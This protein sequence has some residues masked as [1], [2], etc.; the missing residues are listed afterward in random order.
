VGVGCF[1]GGAPLELVLRPHM[2]G[3]VTQAPRLLHIAHFAHQVVKHLGGEAPRLGGFVV[4]QFPELTSPGLGQQAGALRFLP[5]PGEEAVGVIGRLDPRLEL[6]SQVGREEGL[7]SP[8]AGE[9]E[10]D[11]HG[12]E[13]PPEPLRQF[14]PQMPPS[15]IAPRGRNSCRWPST[16]GGG[17]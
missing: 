8:A 7:P 16:G 11:R 6:R 17:L 5:V 14:L 13:G 12:R 2:E 15:C 9:G 4:V 10:G 3:V 1:W